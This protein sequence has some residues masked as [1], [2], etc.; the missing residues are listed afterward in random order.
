MGRGRSWLR[1]DCGDWGILLIILG[2]VFILF[3]P[4]EERQISELF[5]SCL[6]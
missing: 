5:Q 3:S 2:F 6:A 1:V 4:V